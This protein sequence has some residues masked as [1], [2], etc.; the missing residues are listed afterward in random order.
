M[1]TTMDL[2][3]AD[4]MTREVKHVLPD[5]ILGD[6]ALLMS[7]ERISSLLIMSDNQ[8]LGIITERDLLRLLSQ[9]A[10]IQTP[11]SGV[12]SSP[13][14][15]VPHD[16]DFLAA[17]AMAI[18]HHVRHLVV[19]DETES[20]IG[21]VSETDFRHHLGADLLRKFDDLY[22][23]MD[24]NFPC[25]SPDATLDKAL[26]MMLQDRASYVLVVE[27]DR[28]VGILTE[29]DLAGFLASNGETAQLLMRDVM[30]APVLSVAKNMPVFEMA[31]MMQ[32]QNFRHLLVV[33]DD[34]KV[35]GML[36]LHKL[37]EGITSNMMAEER[38]RHQ[39]TLQNSK[40]RTESILRSIVQMIPDLIWLKD[41]DGVYL[42]CNRTFER[43]F[44]ASEADIVGKTDYCFL[45]KRLAD[46]FAEHDCEVMKAGESRVREKWLTFAYDGHRAYVE[47]IK[48]P[49][50]DEH[51]QLIGVLGIARDITER[52]TAKNKIQHL[53]QLYAALS[54]CNQDIVRTTSGAE[55]FP[56]V[57]L[58]A[59]K[60]GGYKMAW[61]GWLDSETQQIKPIAFY[62]E[63]VE[64]LHDLYV[65]AD[66]SVAAGRGPTGT[67]VRENQPFWCQDFLQDPATEPWHVSAATFGWRA[68]ASL[69]LHRN[70]EVVG[71][72]SLY[73][74]QIN[75]F[76]GSSRNLLLE[77]SMD[78]SFALDNFEREV[79]RTRLELQ[80]K[81][82]MEV[83]ELL[84]KGESLPSLLRFLA[85]SYETMYPGLLCSIL[86]LSPDGLHLK[87][88]AAPSLPVAYC[89]AIDGAAIGEY[90]GSCGTAA[91]TRET[92]FVSDIATDPRW[93]D[94][95]DLALENGLAACWSI[96]VFSTQ[97]QV[98][99]TFALYY[100]T[101][102]SPQADEIVS[103]IR[104]AHLASLAIERAQNEIKLRKLS[105]AV[106]QSPN[107]IVIADLDANIEYANAAFVMSSGYSLAEV[108]GKNVLHTSKMSP[109]D[110]DDMWAHLNVGE[111]WR[112]EFS[113]RHKE[114][115]TYIESVM[116]SPMCLSEG[117]VTN[118][119]SI[120]E[121]VTEKKQA[122]ARISQLAH[123]DALTGLPN[124]TLLKSR[125]AYSMNLAQRS[126]TQL[127]VLFLDVDHFK[128]INDTLGH[129][130]GDELLIQLATR[131]KAL[132][133][134]ED[135][136]SRMGGDEFVL[137]LPGT[138]GDGAAHVAAKLLETVAQVC[139]IAQY[140]L[141]VTP[142]IGIAIY[143]SDGDDFDLL[144]QRADVAMYRAKQD[145]RNCFRFFTNEMQARSVRRLQL[146]S[147][148]RQALAREQFQL[149][150][151]PQI[152][153]QDGRVVGAEALLRWTHPEFGQVS[154]A[155]FIPIA[156][157]TG[158][159]LSIGEWVLRAAVQQAKKWMVSGQ[160]AITIAVNL[161]AV[162]FRHVQ[163]P[164]L[165]VH[166]LDEAGL[167]P[168]Y[169][170][171]EL[172]E[173][174]AMDA[175]LEAIAVMDNLHARGIRMSIDDFGTGYSSLSYLRKFK[176][177]KLKI[178]QS[179]VRDITE[180][181]ESRAIVSAIITL[182]SS[183]GFQTIAEGVE[184]AG[185][186]SF[187]RLQGCNEVQG[188]YFSKPLA[189]IEFES[190]MRRS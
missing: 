167:P 66:A 120:R 112:G 90:A 105:Q 96:P 45:D 14:L 94:Y 59:V 146:E 57:C 126:E 13:V 72:F 142:S 104:G 141:V 70:G 136:L 68:S 113:S 184:T 130:T 124:Q 182:A 58:D 119:L 20:V 1:N 91:Y 158:L 102:R 51:G 79:V 186:L 108:T 99:G 150:Y 38:W 103:L 165:V 74:D 121:D 162:Q 118:Y 149:H 4:I 63:G 98:L 178:D 114:G 129:R 48:S 46:S 159:I 27:N 168:Q 3:L 89:K 147:G 35:L 128:N 26:D 39:K 37:M 82:E 80:S 36:T 53:S 155:E 11:V 84:A 174:A 64:Y 190:F 73:A 61:V 19:I 32:R 21:I 52:H 97:Q 2:T 169:I 81:S 117:K 148:L 77:M 156:E 115:T 87:H 42:S 152:S 93:R 15:T 170:E 185:Q 164:E 54:Q 56:Q 189:V 8:P 177:G 71:A 144:Y 122:E 47:T 78:I 76:D 85:S 92:V 109:V 50:L 181:P 160:A 25:L 163:L 22:A 24:K 154:P 166:I 83:L 134:E 101:P 41:V 183:M 116:M 151:Q 28:A 125:V 132:V 88:G 140:E 139:H 75:A 65:S 106:E 23:V 7:Q 62:G 138:D 131:L 30:H 145:G 111:T 18:D 176:V 12:M 33:D 100:S 55:L 110:Y 135:T 60:Y 157:E 86:L 161:S 44:G 16:L 9:H 95:K 5:C 69:P 137:V 188:Y 107:S 179:F 175:P 172:T 133:R 173:S 187:L 67:A 171:L 17:Y 40:Q 31:S 29:R 143:P 43:F 34:K 123:F 180:D 153:M 127:A 6:A 49:M 10:N